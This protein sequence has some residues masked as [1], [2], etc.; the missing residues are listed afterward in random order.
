MREAGASFLTLVLFPGSGMPCSGFGQS[1]TGAADALEVEFSLH[2]EL[3]RSHLHVQPAVHTQTYARA[4][5]R[6]H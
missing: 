6:A 4:R 5:G 2:R 3:L 1:E